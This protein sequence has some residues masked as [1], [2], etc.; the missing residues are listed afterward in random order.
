[1]NLLLQEVL[2]IIISITSLVD[3]FA[4]EVQVYRP[5]LI[6]ICPV[7]LKLAVQ[8]FVCPVDRTVLSHWSETPE[9]GVWLLC[10]T[11]AIFAFH[12][13]IHVSVYLGHHDV[14]QE[15]SLWKHRLLTKSVMDCF[16]LGIFRCYYCS[17]LSQPFKVGFIPL[18]MVNLCCWQE[19]PA[20][21]SASWAI[22]C[23]SWPDPALSIHLSWFGGE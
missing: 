16:L 21:K 1:M 3:Q 7:D 11:N 10:F 20:E 5:H 6:E 22:I 12:V 14:W 9:A 15:I 19:T 18:Q 2:S 8:R 4:K 13:L 23:G 17:A